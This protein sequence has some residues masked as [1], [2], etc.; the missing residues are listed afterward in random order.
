[1]KFWPL[2]WS[3][4]RR[5]KFRTTFTL[6]SILVAFL[7]FGYLAAI[8]KAFELGVDVTGADRLVVIHKVSLIQPLPYSYFSE[9]KQ[10]PGVVDVSHATWFAG[11]YQEPKNFFPQ[12]AVEAESWLR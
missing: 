2:V 4:L 3:N 5:K 11:I 7:L 12:M 1:M 10:M 6:L 8:N 9:L